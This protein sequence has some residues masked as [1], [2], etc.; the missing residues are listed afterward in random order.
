MAKKQ[1]SKSNRGAM[2]DMAEGLGRFLGEA[3]AKWNS[4]RGEREQ[5]VKALTDIRDRASTLLSEV[6]AGVQSGYQARRGRPPGSKN[7]AL[8]RAT[9]QAMVHVPKKKRKGGLTPEGRAA[10]AAA[11][12]A[13]WAAIRAKTKNAK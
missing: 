9:T 1:A 3:E 12:K 7:Q 13:R 5:V 11:Q 10:I 2:M 6:G 8:V 4:W